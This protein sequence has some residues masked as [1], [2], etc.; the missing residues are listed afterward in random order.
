MEEELRPEDTGDE[1]PIE[2]KSSRWD[3]TQITYV[4]LLALTIVL[5]AW[6]WINK[7]INSYPIAIPIIAIL[8]CTI[9][10][11]D[12]M[13]RIP[14]LLIGLVVVSLFISLA[15]DLAQGDKTFFKMTR[16]ICA[17]LILSIS[18][19][20]IGYYTMRHTPDRNRDKRIIIG[21]TSFLFGIAAFCTYAVVYYILIWV[22]GGVV[23]ANIT[24]EEFMDAMFDVFFTSLAVWIIY[25]LDGKYKFLHNFALNFF[26]NNKVKLGKDPVQEVLD[27]IEVGESDLVEFKSTLRTNV[28]TGEKDKRM[29]L[30]VLKTLVAFLNSNGGDLLIGVK[31]DGEIIGM[32]VQT[33][34]NRDKINLHVTNMISIQI[35]DDFI[36][37][38]NYQLVDINDKTVLHFT[39]AKSNKPAFVKVGEVETFYARNGPASIEL[40]GSNLLRYFENRYK[41]KKK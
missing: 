11:R 9:L 18:G 23:H 17:G 14:P 6:G 5:M 41:M 8:L 2:P 25:H 34:D 40:K 39:V 31:D 24:W 1:I 27:I 38:I 19:L 16:N 29:E 12:K 30:A 20:I 33:F 26:E 10:F 22:T 15:S 37:Y 3:K 21:L 4:I 32:D 36:P 35:G 13:F 28:H 7:D